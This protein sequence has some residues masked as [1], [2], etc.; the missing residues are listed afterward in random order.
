MYH[1]KLYCFGVREMFLLTR[2]VH[3]I[4]KNWELLSAALFKSSKGI[5][6]PG[7]LGSS[8]GNCQE[9]IP[10]PGFPFGEFHSL[11]LK[12][13]PL[14][15]P[16]CDGNSKKWVPEHLPCSQEPK[17]KSITHIHFLFKISLSKQTSSDCNKF[18]VFGAS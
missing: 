7:F 5:S 10:E 15:P 9:F 1:Q 3:L 4:F 18:S 8:L 14:V 16:V 17:F 12:N 6:V 2:G 13:F 11:K